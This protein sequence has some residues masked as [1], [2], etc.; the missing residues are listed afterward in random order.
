MYLFL[1]VKLA[2]C[3]FVR[4][5]WWWWTPSPFSLSRKVFVLHFRRIPFLLFLRLMLWQSSWS[6]H[7][8][9]K[10]LTW[11]LVSVPTT[12]FLINFLANLPGKVTEDGPSTWAAFPLERI[13]NFQLL[14]QPCHCGCLR[15][16]INE[17]KIGLFPFSF[18][19]SFKFKKGKPFNFFFP[20]SMLTICNI[21][22]SY[23]M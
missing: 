14:A 21:L 8:Q 10:N 22:L 5:I 6:C 2:F 4:L 13:T 20:V 1:P 16:R 12:P 18:C 11:V 23:D 9:C 19:D 7:L 3:N 17:W 15:E